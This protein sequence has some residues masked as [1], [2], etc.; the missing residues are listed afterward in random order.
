MSAVL[1]Q[2]ATAP[3]AIVEINGQVPGQDSLLPPAA[4][5]LLA[6]LHRLVEPRRQALLAARVDR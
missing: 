6:D 2:H 1:A 4:L 3:P 5:E